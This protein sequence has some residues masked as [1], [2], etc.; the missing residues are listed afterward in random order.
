MSYH[1]KCYCP[2]DNVHEWLDQMSCPASIRQVHSDLSV[3][4]KVDFKHVAE[5]VI[6]RFGNNPGSVAVCHYVVK[7]NKV[8]FSVDLSINFSNAPYTNLSV[9]LAFKQRCDRN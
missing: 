1:E 4:Q 8:C 2:V 7:D 9:R 3:F 6:R 5:E